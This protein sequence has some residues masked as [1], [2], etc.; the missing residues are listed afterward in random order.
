[1]AQISLMGGRS[2]HRRK[3]GKTGVGGRGAASGQIRRAGT[4]KARHCPGELDVAA[5]ILIRVK[6]TESQRL[7]QGP[8][9]SKQTSGLEAW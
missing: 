3:R 8:L 7:A 5:W 6:C 4:Q 2:K 1:M 9:S